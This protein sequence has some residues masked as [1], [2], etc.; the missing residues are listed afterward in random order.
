MKKLHAN[1]YFEFTK[2]QQKALGVLFAIILGLQGFFYFTTTHL[3]K[4]SPIS[5][6]YY[7]QPTANAVSSTAVKNYPIYPFNPNFISDYKAYKFGMSPAQ[8]N[9]LRVYRSKNLFA[10]SASE[11]QQVTGVSNAL[12]A[13]MSPYF[14][15][16]DWINK[17]RKTNG[18]S[19]K[20]ANATP[21]QLKVDVN[22]AT[23]EDLKQIKGIGDGFSSRILA[24][25]QKL[26]FFV[27]ME[28]LKD[29]W[30]LPPE[31]IT[32]LHDHFQV[33]ELPKIDKTNVNNCNLKELMQVPYINYN[34]AKSILIYRS[35]NE[36][37][38][39]IEDLTKIERFPVDKINIIALY[40]EF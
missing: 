11:F 5:Q 37:P 13:K 22:Q 28:Q 20:F 17:S 6:W 29:I 21:N 25:R 2:S 3:P 10:N 8:L 32:Q 27:S 12:L 7:V 26:G 35:K 34:I 31:V 9:R 40:L 39:H 15:F 19:K 4:D 36:A 30:G 23:A 1:I 18:Y 24:A 16:P 14:K 33:G 38:L